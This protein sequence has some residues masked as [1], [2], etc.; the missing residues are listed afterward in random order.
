MKSSEFNELI[1]ASI[2][3]GTILEN[4]GKGTSEISG[5]SDKNISY[6]RRK[7][8]IR[9]AFKDLFNAYSHFRGQ[10]VSSSMLKDF[11]SKVF[12]SNARPAGHSCNCTF[13]FLI[14]VRL[15]LAGKIEGKGVTRNPFFVNIF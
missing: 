6:I 4:P 10:Q 5:Y 9:V 12:D 2:P 15:N 11:E 13:F 8:T 7:S 14:L 3:V 1:E